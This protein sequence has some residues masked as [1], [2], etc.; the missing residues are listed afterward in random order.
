MPKL[1][2]MHGLRN[3]ADPLF[4]IISLQ[5]YILF[6]VFPNLRAVYVVSSN[7]DIFI[8]ASHFILFYTCK[9][10][11]NDRLMYTFISMPVKYWLSFSDNDLNIY[12]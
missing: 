3:S 12:I 5:S 1:E 9:Q 4:L 8:K 11:I 2:R 7:G 6:V 10:P